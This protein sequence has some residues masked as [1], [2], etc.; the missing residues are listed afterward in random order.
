MGMNQKDATYNAV[1][2]V[3]GYAGEGACVP[4]KEQRSQINAV[5]FEGIRAGTV[6][7]D[8]EKSDSD[9]QGYISGLISNW[10]RKDERLNGGVKYA[11]KNPGSRAGS[12]DPQL[13]ALRTLIA[14]PELSD[15][16][17]A[18]IQVHID[19]RTAEMTQAKLAK[20][21]DFSALPS[22]LAAKFSK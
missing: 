8:T 22:D 3:T 7:M 4:T 16:D 14:Q 12:T 11:A 21:I 10:L 2:N 20:A 6:Q 9:L 18:E 5:L 1:V 15:S 19:T 17:R 13:K